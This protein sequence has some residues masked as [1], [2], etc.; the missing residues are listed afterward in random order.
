MNIFSKGLIVAS[1]LSLFSSCVKKEMPNTDIDIYPKEEFAV[2]DGKLKDGNPVIGSINMAYK[3]Y[4]YKKDYPWC[5]NIAIA[6]ELNNVYD[7]GLPFKEESQIAYQLEDELL[8]EIQKLANTHYIGHIFN[9]T[10]LD[11]YVYLDK[12]EN[13]HNYLQTQVN[14]EDI[15]RGFGYEINKDAN[16]ET[17]NYLLH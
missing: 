3:N 11:I 7:N 4:K 17:V 1:I 9:D 2:I 13:V 8:T 6:L 15:L 16:W 5:L 10:F 12:P 14:R